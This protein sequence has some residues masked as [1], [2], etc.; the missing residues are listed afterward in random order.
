MSQ[1]TNAA[2]SG[3]QRSQ[4]TGQEKESIVN[5]IFEKHATLSG[6]IKEYRVETEVVYNRG[7]EETTTAVSKGQYFNKY[8]Y[9]YAEEVKKNPNQR[10]WKKPL[11]SGQP[12]LEERFKNQIAP[13]ANLGSVFNI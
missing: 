6:I 2:T 9:A 1:D 3:I 11:S 4:V 5:T 8:A 12:S 13:P 7:R 10:S